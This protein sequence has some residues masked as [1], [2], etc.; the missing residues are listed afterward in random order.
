MFALPPFRGV[1]RRIILIALCAFFIT[2][3]LELFAHGIIALLLNLTILEPTQALHGLIWQFITYP[4]VGMGLLS[5]LLA[6]LSLWFFGAAL[7]EERGARWISELFFLS[8]IGG[9]VL[10]CLLY[11]LTTGHVWGVT[12][13]A[14]A[15]GLWPFVMAL[16]VAYATLHP[17]EQLSFNFLFQVKAKYLA[18]IYLLVYAAVSIASQNRF[19][20]VVALSNALFAY[21]YIR[22][23]PN[24]GVRRATSEAWFGWRNAYYRMKRRRAAKKFTVYMRK[25]GRDISFDESGRYTGPADDPADKRDPRDP[26]DSNDRRWM[27]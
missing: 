24:R 10:A 13:L 18:A 3:V 21:L 15:S 27:N 25:Q 11:A 22:F 16:L 4:F 2:L 7:E 19:S 12:M 17:E 6:A 9:A 8:T 5:L 1:T 20:A 23:A 26:R 14:Q